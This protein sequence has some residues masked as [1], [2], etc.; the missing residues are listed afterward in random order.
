MVMKPDKLFVII[1]GLDRE[2]TMIDFEMCWSNLPKAK[3]KKKKKFLKIFN[4]TVNVKQRIVH[5]RGP[6]NINCSTI[7][8]MQGFKTSL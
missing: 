1:F 6:S 2:Q 8:A 5:S 3:K 7:V 4:Y